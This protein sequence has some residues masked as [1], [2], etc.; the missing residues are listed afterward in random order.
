MT[1]AL[2]SAAIPSAIP[3]RSWRQALDDYC[4]T[5]RTRGSS[6]VR[7]RPTTT[8]PRRGGGPA[9]PAPCIAV[10]LLYM[11]GTC[12]ARS[13]KL[14]AGFSSSAHT[15]YSGTESTTLCYRDFGICWARSPSQ[16]EIDCCC[17]GELDH[18]I[19]QQQ[20]PAAEFGTS[21]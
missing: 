2:E 1:A 12:I 5:I 7:G 8:A 3:R 14:S 17:A 19:Q 10:Q 16:A 15:Q 20:T 4:V 18:R 11:A 9:P 21:Y 6:G 13:S